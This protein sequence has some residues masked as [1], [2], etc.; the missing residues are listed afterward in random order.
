MLDSILFLNLPLHWNSPVSASLSPCFRS[1]IREVP[2]CIYS[3]DLDI[4]KTFSGTPLHWLY[5][6]LYKLL[7]QYC[8]PHLLTLW[9]KPTCSQH[10]ISFWISVF[11]NKWTRPEI[12]PQPFKLSPPTIRQTIY[13]SSFTCWS[14]HTANTPL[15]VLNHLKYLSMFIQQY[16][17]KIYVGLKVLEC[18]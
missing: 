12:S 18:S 14:F 4:T 13:A 2:L 3:T 17:Q 9:N 8:C 11:F 16:P 5:K 7:P 6:L 10:T 1:N 15:R